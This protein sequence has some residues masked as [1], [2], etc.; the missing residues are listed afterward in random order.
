MVAWGFAHTRD[1]PYA[2]E[3][4]QAP[5]PRLKVL[6]LLLFPGSLLVCYPYMGSHT[7]VRYVFGWAYCEWT[8]W[9]FLPQ[10]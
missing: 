3:V 5:S 8:G 4:L 1:C 10:G 9:L 2:E 7:A 6:Y